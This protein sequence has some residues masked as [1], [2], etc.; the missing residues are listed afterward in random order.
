MRPDVF[1]KM[2]MGCEEALQRGVREE[3]SWRG[4]WTTRAGTGDLNAEGKARRHKNTWKA[5]GF[6][7]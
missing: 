7:R 1:T 3:R 2:K 6:V 5:H 4:D